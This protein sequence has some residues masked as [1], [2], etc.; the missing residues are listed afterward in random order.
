MEHMVERAVISSTTPTLNINA[1]VSQQIIASDTS[2]P[3]MSLAD[4][5]RETIIRVLKY[6]NGRIRGPKGAADI[7][8]IKPTTLEARMKKLGII[9][10]HIIQ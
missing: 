8:D 5:E 1:P 9:K 6:C 3:L 4:A 10:E 7:L 2:P